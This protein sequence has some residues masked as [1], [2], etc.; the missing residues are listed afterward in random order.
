MIS[1]GD[2]KRDFKRNFLKEEIGTPTIQGGLHGSLGTS[3]L[4]P[5][6]NCQALVPSPVPLDPIPNPKQSKS[7]SNWD[8]GD[9]II[10]WA[11]NPWGIVQHVQEEGYQPHIT[12]RTGSSQVP[13]GLRMKPLS[14]QVDRWTVRSR[15]WGSSTCS[16]RRL[17]ILIC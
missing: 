15:T 16:G 14:I 7:K 17:S 3:Y 1:K 10:T 8:W 13:K 5:K 6:S 9:T 4:K 2:L 11:T 12:F